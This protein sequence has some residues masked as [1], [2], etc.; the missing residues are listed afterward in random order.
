M[1]GDARQERKRLIGHLA[2]SLRGQSAQTVTPGTPPPHAQY[3]IATSFCCFINLRLT[4]SVRAQ[5]TTLSSHF[6]NFLMVHSA[7]IIFSLHVSLHSVYK[8]QGRISSFI[9]P[10]PVKRLLTPNSNPLPL[11]AVSFSCSPSEP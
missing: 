10:N 1:S 3:R 9:T 7:M 2:R 4:P 8:S 11:E 6:V 5:S